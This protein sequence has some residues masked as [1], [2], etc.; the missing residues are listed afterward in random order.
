MLDFEERAH[1]PNRHP[2]QS[3]SSDFLPQVPLDSC[4]LLRVCKLVRIE[5]L[6]RF[7]ASAN[8]RFIPEEHGLMATS[9]LSMEFCQD[10][11]YSGSP[12]HSMQLPPEWLKYVQVITI[13]VH[14]PCDD[15][16]A[17]T[18]DWSMLMSMPALKKINLVFKAR[19][20]HDYTWRGMDDIIVETID[21]QGGSTWLTGVLVEVVSATPKDVQIAFTDPTEGRLPG[22]AGGDDVVPEDIGGGSFFW[23][24]ASNCFKE[25]RGHD[26]NTTGEHER[27]KQV[28][29]V[30]ERH[31]G[32]AWPIKVEILQALYEKFM[33]LQRT[34]ATSKRID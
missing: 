32:P 13:W 6:S 16:S 30:Y 12:H 9:V 25:R 15:S 23:I 4:A 20:T 24:P 18:S 21:E 5:Y 26:N 34:G 10:P 28:G 2:Y 29:M 17:S 31:H 8:I 1:A 22:L 11:R 19:H 33:T 14:P 7:I 3:E 27:M